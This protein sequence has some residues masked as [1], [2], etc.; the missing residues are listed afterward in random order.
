MSTSEQSAETIIWIAEKKAFLHGENEAGGRNLI[1][2]RHLR[3][4][5]EKN[6]A[7]RVVGREGGKGGE[8]S[9]WSS[10]MGQEREG[11][12]E[13]ER[14]RERKRDGERDE[15]NNP[16]GIILTME[17][18]CPRLTPM[19][20][21]TYLGEVV[22]PASHADSHEDEYQVPAEVHERSEEH[23]AQLRSSYLCE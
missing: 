20:D 4:E 14:E 15:R 2:E 19:P 12:V 23:P 8:R 1:Q 5:K 22:E 10:K 13:R 21:D 6:D 7:E 16:I 3:E 17:L 18:H 11:N 9:A